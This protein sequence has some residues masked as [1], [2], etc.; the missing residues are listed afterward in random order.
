MAY[1]TKLVFDRP[2]IQTP[3]ADPD[4]AYD[5]PDLNFKALFEAGLLEGHDMDLSVDGLVMTINLTWVSE[6]KF[7]EYQDALQDDDNDADW[8]EH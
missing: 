6:E 4:H 8:K 1:Q 3:F 5:S 2:N 7:R